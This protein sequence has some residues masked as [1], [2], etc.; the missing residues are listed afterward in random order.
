M[1]D[2]RLN[3]PSHIRLFADDCVVYCRI[4]NPDDQALLQEDLY[5]ISL[6]YNTWQLKYDK[7]KTKYDS[8]A[9]WPSSTLRKC[10]L[11]LANRKSYNLP[12]GLTFAEDLTWNDRINNTVS[13]ACKAPGFIKH[14]LFILSKTPKLTEYKTFFSSI[15]EYIYIIWSPHQAYL[16]NKLESVQNKASRYINRN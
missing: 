16:I 13:C 15:L 11:N 9:S 7:M 2:V 5:I 12:V 1:K 8:F 6:M 4:T 3:L 10:A 14:N